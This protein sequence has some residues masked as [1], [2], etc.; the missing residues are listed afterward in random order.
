[1]VWQRPD[2]PPPATGSSRSDGGEAGDRWEAAARAMSG[3]AKE[4]STG[5]KE[6][7]PQPPPPLPP[8]GQAATKIINEICVNCSLPGHFAPRCPTI[9]CEKCNKLGHMAQLCQ[10]LRPWECVP[11]MCGFQSPGQ[12]FFYIPDMCIA[13]QSTEKTNNV[14]ITIVEGVASVKE[15]EHEFNAIFAKK[16]G[17]KKWRCT[18]RSIGPNK[19]V[20]RFPNA[21]EVERAC[22]YGKR[23]PLMEGAVVVCITPWTASIGAKGILEKAWVR[24]RNIPIEKRCA[25]HAAYAGALVGITLEVDESTIHKPEYVR[26]LLGCR[27]VERIPPSAEGMLGEQ[28]YDFFYEVEK[29]VTSGASKAQSSIAVDSS[30]SPSFPKKAR[31]G[32]YP[33][34]S[35]GQGETSASM[36]GTY[37]SQNYD[38]GGQRLAVVAE[39]EEEEESDDGNHTELLIETMAREHADE[40]MVHCDPLNGGVVCG[41]NQ[42]EMGKDEMAGALTH[43]VRVQKGAWGILTPIPPSPLYLQ[44]EDTTY[45]GVI[46]P[47]AD[48]VTWPSLPH[49]V[50]LEE[51]SME[52]GENYSSYTVESPSGSPIQDKMVGEEY[53]PRRQMQKLE[54]I[55]EVATNRMR[56]RDAEGLLKAEDKVKL[57]DGVKR[58]AHAA[59]VLADRPFPRD[60]LRLGDRDGIQIG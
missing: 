15:I 43:D 45:G 18:A 14:V 35:M 25:E 19:F 46:S 42:E 47:L 60:R 17:K 53:A 9:R 34:D 44:Y 10:T 21:S 5:A 31:M 13:K 59:A 1:M 48:Y 38:K 8:A 32:S 52:G 58:L 55:E 27:E 37:S 23:M 54:K 30:A 11:L 40:K 49:I 22:C 36:V 29:T 50:P 39:S 56:K 33:A 28:Y 12:G 26:I 2:P 3:A 4:K 7:S 24:V 20:M 51:G 16:P 57:Q 6:P 41:K